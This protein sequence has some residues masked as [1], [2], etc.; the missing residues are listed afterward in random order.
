[1]DIFF[2]PYSL[3]LTQA[4]PGTSNS[5]TPQRQ[6]WLL[7]YRHQGNVGWGD[8]APLPPWGPSLERDEL[9]RFQRAIP[10]NP[11]KLE[12]CHP[13]LQFA[14]SNAK[15][16]AEGWPNHP[17]NVPVNALLFG[18]NLLDQAQTALALGFTC[19]KLK[20]TGYSVEQLAESLHRIH[21][22]RAVPISFRLDANRSWTL[23]EARSFFQLTQDLPID[24]VEEP[25]IHP[26][27]IAQL[28]AESPVALDET[29]RE[30]QA[31]PLLQL[32][33]IRAL[34]IKPSLQPLPAMARVPVVISSSFE[35]GVGIYAL[36]QLAASITHLPAG[37]DTYRW[38]KRDVLASPLRFDNGRLVLQPTPELA[39]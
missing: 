9:R 23:P 29:F 19:L 5:G 25:L 3:P 14:W 22:N 26:G 12:Q 21:S 24:Y 7:E 4:I 35:S 8:V 32:P 18:P 15:Q 16:W 28:H 2:H 6:G 38:L 39:L 17:L 1:M 33:Q 10:Q 34:I 11:H 31:D 37:L 27:E 20:T 36:G 13:A 30:N